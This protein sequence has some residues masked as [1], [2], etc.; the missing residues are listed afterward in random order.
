MSDFSE[1]REQ[2]ETV[3]SVYV[4]SEAAETSGLISSGEIATIPELLPV[5]SQ[6]SEMF[7]KLA[8][9][10]MARAAAQQDPQGGLPMMQRACMYLFAKGV[11]AVLLWA[12]SPDG[13]ISMGFEPSELTTLDISTDLPPDQHRL[14]VDAM[15]GGR[16]LFD[17]HVQFMAGSWDDARQVDVKHVEDEM[18]KTLL[19][20]PRFAMAY[21]VAR[22]YHEKTA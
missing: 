4:M 16:L 7:F 11:E 17:A 21:A 14:A 2:P 1:K 19:W 13:R 18:R 3:D 6:G 10:S 20:I 8:V 12:K 9:Q 15:G 5:L 22:N